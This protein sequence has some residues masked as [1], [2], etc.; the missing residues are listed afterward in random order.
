MA[1][2][3]KSQ[4]QGAAQCNQVSAP[5][6]LP[7]SNVASALQFLASVHSMALFVDVDALATSLVKP[8]SIPSYFIRIESEE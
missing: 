4:G 2:V 8:S 1:K 7:S 3:G 5:A 6:N